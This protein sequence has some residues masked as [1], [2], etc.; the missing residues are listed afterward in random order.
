MKEISGVKYLTIREFAEAKGITV[1]AARHLIRQNGVKAS[2]KL[3]R[4]RYFTVSD[5]DAQLLQI[6]AQNAGR[7]L[8]QAAL[9]HTSYE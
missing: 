5:V 9:R 4:S 6:G 1:S 3:G 8:P 2:I 7:R